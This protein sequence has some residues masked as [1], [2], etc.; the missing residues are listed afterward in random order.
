MQ[1]GTFNAGAVNLVQTM[2]GHGGK[3]HEC[4]MFVTQMT[5]I[6]AEG[7]QVRKIRFLVYPSTNYIKV[8][9]DDDRALGMDHTLKVPGFW[10]LIQDHDSCWR[11]WGNYYQEDVQINRVLWYQISDTEEETYGYNFLPQLLASEP[12][13]FHV[14]ETSAVLWFEQVVRIAVATKHFRI[15]KIDF[16]CIQEQGHCDR[17]Y[18]EYLSWDLDRIGNEMFAAW[19]SWDRPKDYKLMFTV[20]GV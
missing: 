9:T 7:S 15:V 19:T 18:E 14:Y 5:K 3:R 4:L 6:T 20:S 12:K 8:F 2:F 17:F 10:K 16:R 11:E 13:I 1:F